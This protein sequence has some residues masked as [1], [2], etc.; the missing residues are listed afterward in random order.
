MAFQADTAA[1]GGVQSKTC[2]DCGEAK[3]LSDFGTTRTV[4]GRKLLRA[5]CQACYNVQRRAHYARPDVKSAKRDKRRAYEASV[6]LST[7]RKELRSDPAVKAKEKAARD[8]YR[9]KP[10]VQERLSAYKVAYIS[11]P[12]TRALYLF[13][14]IRLRAKKKGLPFDL[15]LDWVR[16][17]VLLG[18]CSLTGMEFDYAPPPNGWRYNPLGP[19]VDQISPGAGYTMANCRVVITALNNAL[20]QYGDDFFEGMAKAFLERRGFTVAPPSK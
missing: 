16:E 18:R 20:S 19:S 1:A 7:K 8:A 10:E 9:A 6:D 17:R 11:Q 3:S 12:E 2:S 14:A 4:A 15:T 5:Q 13:G